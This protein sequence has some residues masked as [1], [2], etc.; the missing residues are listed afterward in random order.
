MAP[1]IEK[2]T[3]ERLLVNAELVETP[4]KPQSSGTIIDA[5]IVKP[6]DFQ[7]CEDCG[8]TI[9]VCDCHSDMNAP[10]CGEPVW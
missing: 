3:V 5:E 7:T 10:L 8:K 4:N 2:K 1:L 9:D 6:E